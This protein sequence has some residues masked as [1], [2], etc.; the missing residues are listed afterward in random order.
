MSKRRTFLRRTA[1]TL[2]AG[3]GVC[4]AADIANAQINLSGGTFNAHS[5]PT[6]GGLN[7]RYWR[8]VP[9]GQVLAIGNT[10]FVGANNVV[11]F[12]SLNSAMSY[13]NGTDG[14]SVPEEVDQVSQSLPILQVPID[15]PAGNG[16]DP[17]TTNPFVGQAIVS[18]DNQLAIWSGV[19]NVTN[20]GVH[21]FW[22]SSDDASM[23]F[24]DGQVVVD[25]NHQQGIV[26]STRTGN[27]N[28]TAGEHQIAILFQEAGGESAVFVEWQSPTVTRTLV[29]PAVNPTNFRS[30]APVDNSSQTVTVTANST[31][32]VRASQASFGDLTLTNSTLS[33][34]G[35]RSA[36]RTTFG[37]ATATGAAGVN[38]AV[39]ASFASLNG[40]G[41]TTFT[42]SGPAGLRID[43]NSTLTNSTNV[44][45]NEGTL[46]ITATGGNQSLGTA[47][48]NLAGGNLGIGNTDTAVATVGNAVSVTANSSVTVGAG[49]G[50]NL[51]TVSINPGLTLT[52]LGNAGLGVATTTIPGG[53]AVTL[54]VQ[55]GSMTTNAYNSGGAATTVT[56]TGGG[57]LN[58]PTIGT[59]LAAGS[60]INV[61]AGV[62]TATNNNVGTSIGATPVNLN[63]GTFRIV[64]VAD[65]I[66]NVEGL[67]VGYLPGAFNE[68][69]PQPA[70]APNGLGGVRLDIIHGQNGLIPPWV[71]DNETWIYTGQVFDADGV[72]SFAEHIDDNTLVK[73]NG[74]QVLRNTAWDAPTFGVANGIPDPDG[75]NWYDLEIRLG[76][77]GGGQGPSG[78]GNPQPGWTATYGFGFSPDAEV[79]ANGANYFAPAEPAGG[80]PTLFRTTGFG[81]A[82]W[83]SATIGATGGNST[84]DVSGNASSVSLG[85]IPLSGNAT[86]N[87]IGKSDT[88]IQTIS[89][90]AGTTSTF[91]ANGTGMSAQNVQAA[92]ANLNVGGALTVSGTATATNLQANGT[93]NL[94]GTVTATKV[95]AAGGTANLSGTA[96]VGTLESLPGGNTNVSVNLPSTT[97]IKTD[98]GGNIN[99][100]GGAGTINASTVVGNQTNEG[101]VRFQSGTTNLGGAKLIA[102]P[103]GVTEGLRVGYIDANMD[104]NGTPA[105]E[106]QAPGPAPNAFGGIRLD[107]I[108]GQENDDPHWVGDDETWIYQGQIFDADGV[109][110]FAENIDDDV[111][112][113]VNGHQII[114]DAGWNV[115]T[116]GVYNNNVPDPDNDNWYDV[117]IRLG[118]RGGGA[119]PVTGGGWLAG[120]DGAGFGFGF[121]P[122]AETS[123]D[124]VNY[125]KP[126]ETAG[127]GPTFMRTFSA[128]GNIQVDA[129]AV[130]T[131]AGFINHTRVNV[132]GRLNLT[133]NGTDAGTSSVDSLLIPNAGILDI[134]DN[135]LVIRSTPG[136]KDTELAAVYAE[137]LSAQNGVDANFITNW[138]GPGLTSS[139]AHGQRCL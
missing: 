67:T 111:L 35:V 58:L 43:G 130:G 19:L 102:S 10:P 23:V 38:A 44:V 13:L 117:D 114:R 47:N 16:M 6:D 78:G 9:S 42:K 52:K 122:D 34:T 77:G 75:D 132:E 21:D 91:N 120:N 22:T 74:V 128:F 127:G 54:D 33:L 108:H 90:A 12:R 39:D 105:T 113:R 59:P 11:P 110:T 76:E 93:L 1:L 106:T 57:T 84:L 116:F 92:G 28:L 72:F 118:E 15:F 139:T 3:A 36:D 136:G 82:S 73:V 18:D 30:Y 37:A 137:I 46:A 96:N 125:I 61:N 86:L 107:V 17:S 24:I 121:S 51:S 26:G 31:I 97:T 85:S 112:I 98:L 124:A 53:G 2:A 138:D 95:I 133:P 99:F 32:D 109:F 123:A 103:A 8:D 131:V 88:S 119:G 40:A 135:D 20:A 60:S 104:L 69:D 4:A 7:A 81:P 49:G 56:K 101:Q 5:T 80:G 134:R 83:T 48:I 68:T 79:D 41:L 14:N 87:V 100:A 45:I 63:G 115:P 126:V 70:S 66:P 50:A 27:I 71:G 65:P 94:P 64:S 89:V 62:V 55:F 29:D 25:N 129:G